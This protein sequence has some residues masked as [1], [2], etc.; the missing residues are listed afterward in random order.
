ML[1]KDQKKYVSSAVSSLGK[2]FLILTFTILI[3]WFNCSFSAFAR[4][5]GI[6]ED[7]V[8]AVNFFHKGR[9]KKAL[10]AFESVIRRDPNTSEA[11]EAL[12]YTAECLYALENWAGAV[13]KY[14]NF[15]NRSSKQDTIERLVPHFAESLVKT[16]NLYEAIQ[17]YGDWL[18]K[19]KD[20]TQAKKIRER[21]I[22]LNHELAENLIKKKKY[23]QAK[24]ILDILLQEKNIKNGHILQKQLAE[25][26][27]FLKQWPEA[28]NVYKE[29]RSRNPE[30]T[31]QELIS[32]RII[33]AGF[34]QKT[35]AL[36]LK[37]AEGF[38][39]NYP[40]SSL[41]SEVIYLKAWSLYMSG[42]YKKAVEFLFSRPEFTPILD[43]QKCPRVGLFAR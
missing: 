11:V 38:L 9:Y 2:S 25:C 39:M 8:K 7:L 27:F 23:H 13:E 41:C 34:A 42:Q 1:F 16:G 17:I 12:F 24:D 6:P 40:K 43:M 19:Y 18:E 15:L 36:V 30:D 35:W 10:K 20:S 26:H 28:I 32:Y 22:E 29:V 31:L 4:D 14:N 21:L 33:L 5:S 3:F 37:E